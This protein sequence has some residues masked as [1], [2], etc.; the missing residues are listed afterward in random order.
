MD[1]LTDKIKE[2]ITCHAI[3]EYPNECCGIII[4]NKKTNK[5]HVKKCKN[6]SENKK[7]NFEI[8][9]EEYLKAKGMGK[10][11]AY[12]HSHPNDEV[13]I[14]SDADKKVSAGHGIPLIMY[15]VKSKKFLEY[16]S[17]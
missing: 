3:Q 5:T 1:Y 11:T 12:Y 14:F 13:G 8:S 15:C 9:A 10:I 17:K 2:K 6:I 7:N 4:S 16:N